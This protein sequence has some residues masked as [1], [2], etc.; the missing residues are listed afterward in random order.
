MAQSFSLGIRKL[1]HDLSL[2]QLPGFYWVNIARQS[3]A[4]LFFQ[5]IINSQDADARVALIC[6]GE[7]DET[8]FNSLY[9]TKLEQFPYYV[10]P[11]KKAALFS[12][13][14]DLMRALKPKKRLLILYAPASLWGD[15]SQESMARWITETGEWLQRRECT[16]IILSHSGGGDKLKNILISQHRA[17]YG[18]ASL[19]WQQDHAQY[20]VSWWSTE[21]GMTANQVRGLQPEPEGWRVMESQESAPPL[22]LN[23]EQLYLAEKS[24]LEGAP[25]LSGNWRLFADNGALAARGMS[26][27]AAT[28]IFA[29]NKIGEV[30][31]LA[32]QIH[33][34]RSQRGKAMKIVVRE[35]SASLRSSD[36]R[37]LLA[38]GANIIV[39][40]SEPLSRFL[41]RLES[42]QGQHFTKHVPTDIEE[43]LVMMRPLRVKGYLPPERFVQ[44]VKHLMSNT[45]I[46]E[47]SKG[48][49]V[50]LHPVVGL[51]AEQALTICHLRRFGDVATLSQGRLFLFL[52]T[53]RINEL[54]TALKSIFPLP[55]N[56]IFSRRAV[57]S[58]DVQIF[59]EIKILSENR[60]D[61]IVPLVNHYV[62]DNKNQPERRDAAVRR[63][64]TAITLFTGD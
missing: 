60:K 45:L 17:L 6:S 62:H 47:G 3:D 64:P 32:R 10:L 29:L 28:L 25:A 46:P 7:S 56:E 2:L 39:T 33:R 42:V 58:Q 43:M 16:L 11:E 34:L 61:E 59:S 63:Q 55:V 4:S 19:N 40:H 51:L 9:L 5:Q 27:H 31:D 35:M 38:C 18:L 26:F 15:I 54:D 22:L 1:W 14:D 41:S 24:V 53:C 37:L 8:L 44:S 36:E 20:L 52:S 30:D 48:L 23:D 49:L 57:W 12:L 13:T 21:N 50:S